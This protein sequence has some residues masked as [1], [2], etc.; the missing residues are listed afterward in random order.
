MTL[1]DITKKRN[2]IID[3]II[4][5]PDEKIELLFTL[6]SQQC[7]EFDQTYQDQSQTSLEY[8]Q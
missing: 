6:Y 5:L 8:V 7:E 1:D 4:N 2:D 3:R